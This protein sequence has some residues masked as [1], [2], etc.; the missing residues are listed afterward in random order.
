MQTY[1]TKPQI[2]LHEQWVKQV[3]VYEERVKQ[4][5][6]AINTIIELLEVDS[7]AMS[8][9][10]LQVELD[11]AIPRVNYESVL[12]HLLNMDDTYMYSDDIRAF[13]RGESEQRILKLLKKHVPLFEEVTLA[14]SEA[15]KKSEVMFDS[16]Y[17]ANERDKLRGTDDYSDLYELYKKGVTD[18]DIEHAR[19]VISAC[20]DLSD[21]AKNMKRPQ[22]IW[23]K[24][25]PKTL[26]NDKGERVDCYARYVPRQLVSSLVMVQEN[27]H[28]MFESPLTVGGSC[29]QFYIPGPDGKMEKHYTDVYLSK[30]SWDNEIVYTGNMNFI[31]R[32][33]P[34]HREKS[35]GSSDKGH[36]SRRTHRKFNETRKS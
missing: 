16:S 32:A 18:L 9:E 29:L 5:R 24:G 28:K 7:F 25:T 20:K 19:R 30:D 2:K 31:V 15:Q 34:K 23:V 22:R 33:H 36:R 27:I 14:N 11:K 1:I 6:A 21:F 17:L 13:H 26:L 35:K 8:A 3:K 12:N 10:D 4:G